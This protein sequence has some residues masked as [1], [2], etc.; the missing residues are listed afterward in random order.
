MLNRY[1][2]QE[3]MADYIK[4]VR[5]AIENKGPSLYWFNKPILLCEFKESHCWLVEGYANRIVLGIDYGFPLGSEI[6]KAF[7]NSPLYFWNNNNL[8]PRYFSPYNGFKKNYSNED[9]EIIKYYLIQNGA[10][11]KIKLMKANAEMNPQFNEKLESEARHTGYGVN[12]DHT[13]TCLDV[14]AGAKSLK[15]SQEI[16]KIITSIKNGGEKYLTATYSPNGTSRSRSCESSLVYYLKNYEW[17]PDRKGVFHKPSD[18]ILSQ[19]HPFFKYDINEIQ[20][21]PIIKAIGLNLIVVDDSKEE[22][23]TQL[24]KEADKLGYV[25]LSKKDYNRIK[26]YL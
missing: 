17:L 18:I 3:Y 10:I 8:L 5:Y 13:I 2:L 23:I 11:T 22:Q 25:L 14:M 20:N 15:L 9:F 12:E 19:L 7:N 26:K 1:N 24:K 4:L 16:W 6:M 21:N